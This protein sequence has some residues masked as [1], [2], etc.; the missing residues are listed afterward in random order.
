MRYSTC[1]LKY[2]KK[3]GSEGE[4]NVPKPTLNNFSNFFISQK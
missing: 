3:L 4:G 1:K 2:L